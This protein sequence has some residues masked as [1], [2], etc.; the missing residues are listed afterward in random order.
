MGMIQFYCLSSQNNYD[1]ITHYTMRI[2]FSRNN[3]FLSKII[4]VYNINKYIKFIFQEELHFTDCILIHLKDIQNYNILSEYT[5]TNIC[6]KIYLYS[7]SITQAFIEL[8][9][10]AGSSYQGFTYI[11]MFNPHRFLLR[12]VLYYPQVIYEKHGFQKDQ[13]TYSD[14]NNELMTGSEFSLRTLL[15]SVCP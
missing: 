7:V 1:H 15:P 8:I 9:L 13:I 12:Q 5:L 2:Y 10:C 11:N 3:V 4:L 6:N 14:L